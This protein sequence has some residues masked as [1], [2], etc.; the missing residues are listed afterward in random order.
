MNYYLFRLKFDTAVHFGTPDSALSL[1][2]SEIKFCADTLFSALC[3]EAKNGN[4]L[5]SD[6]MPWKGKQLY[7]PK[8]C[9]S[10]DHKRDIPAE[11]RKA[12]KKLSWIPVDQF[13]DF[14]SSIHGGDAFNVA[15]AKVEFGV[16]S[17]TT[18]VS[19]ASGKDSEPYQVGLFTFAEDA[20]LWLIIGCEDDAQCEKMRTLLCCLGLSGIGGKTSA[21]YGKFRVLS[22]QK[23]NEA[24]NETEKWLAD[25]LKTEKTGRYLLLSAAL[26]LEEDLETLMPSAEYSLIRRGGFVQS[27]SYAKENRKKE[28]QVF[29][30]A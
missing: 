10:S 17:E 21:G 30:A 2:T 6:A 23:L 16:H 12:V 13:A 8:P 11:Q 15:K 4:L 3:H 26:P 9:V 1:Y 14:S 27:D 25:A 18:K 29:F 19:I 24:G 20:G 7:L 5:L 22:V 28:T